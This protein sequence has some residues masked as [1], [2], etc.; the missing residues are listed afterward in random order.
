MKNSF[1]DYNVHVQQWTIPCDSWS[2]TAI[3]LRLLSSSSHRHDF[4][5]Q[6]SRDIFYASARSPGRCPGLQ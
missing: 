2:Q 5:H 4:V 6:A 3:Y 1:N